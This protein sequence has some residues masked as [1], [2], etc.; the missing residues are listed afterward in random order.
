MSFVDL[1]RYPA[2]F[3]VEA[4][5]CF[6][7]EQ[8]CLPGAFLEL[9]SS[10]A[11]ANKAADAAQF[12]QLWQASGGEVHQDA[13]GS[14]CCTGLRRLGGLPVLLVFTALT[15]TGVRAQRPLVTGIP[16]LRAV[17]DPSL[18]DSAMVAATP[19]DNGMLALCAE[20]GARQAGLACAQREDV[21]E[22]SRDTPYGCYLTEPG[23]AAHLC[24]GTVASQQAA[25][26]LRAACGYVERR[27][28][29][30]R[31]DCAQGKERAQKELF[32]GS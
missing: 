28:D 21:P 14:A 10:S 9:L 3:A 4:V 25:A 8:D 5:G 30:V 17:F 23:N 27:L 31:A 20:D 26:A 6:A 2:W 11:P 16:L 22:R 13:D 18:A 32:A 7:S 15:G 29:I 12:V 24:L 1:S 19:W